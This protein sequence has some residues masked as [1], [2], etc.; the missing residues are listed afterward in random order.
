M[1]C[2]WDIGRARTGGRSTRGIDFVMITQLGPISVEIRTKILLTTQNRIKPQ[3]SI[4][5]SVIKNKQ[6]RNCNLLKGFLQ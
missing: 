5:Y 2:W 3:E 6:D 1:N 4:I